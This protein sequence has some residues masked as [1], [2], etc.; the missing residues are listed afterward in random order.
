MVE[1]V[2]VMAWF[3]GFGVGMEVAHATVRGVE[4]LVEKIKD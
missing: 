1:V 3:V 2:R 4:R